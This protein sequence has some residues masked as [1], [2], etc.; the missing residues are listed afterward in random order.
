MDEFTLSDT[1]EEVGV[2][3]VGKYHL[4]G[5][6]QEL[7]VDVD[8]LN[9]GNKRA[10]KR[11]YCSEGKPDSINYHSMGMRETNIKGNNRDNADSIS[12]R[13]GS[14]VECS[15]GKSVNGLVFDNEVA[16]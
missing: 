5:A 16:K 9:Q 8:I 11:L 14:F 3:P 15:L 7:G 2:Y 13:A 4:C 1:E 12:S 10:A 6:S